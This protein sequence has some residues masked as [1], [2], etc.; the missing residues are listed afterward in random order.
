MGQI[1][2]DTKVVYRNQPGTAL[3]TLWTAP[4]ANSGEQI[5]EIICTNTTG[6]D[7]RISLYLVPNGG[8]A[9]VTNAIMVSKLIPANDFIVLALCTDMA[10]GDFIAGSQVTGNAITVT[11]T[12]YQK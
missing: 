3:T 11:I 2:D 12:N 10:P 6:A 7:A 1:I 8:T 9:G 4:T 5:K